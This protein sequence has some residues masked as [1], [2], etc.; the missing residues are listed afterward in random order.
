MDSNLPVIA[1]SK[2]NCTVAC[3]WLLFKRKSY[4]N[5]HMFSFQNTNLTVTCI[6]KIKIHTNLYMIFTKTNTEY[7]GTYLSFCVCVYVQEVKK[8]DD[9][10]D[11]L[12]E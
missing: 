8:G 10:Q 4:S 2:S 11:E 12:Q 7:M 6:F 5:L 1:F 3:L 9:Q